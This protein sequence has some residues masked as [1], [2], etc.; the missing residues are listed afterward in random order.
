MTA[1]P[2]AD[3][4]VG[5]AQ[6]LKAVESASQLHESMCEL[7]GDP[8][9]RWTRTQVLFYLPDSFHTVADDYFVGERI[10]I[11]RRERIQ[12]ETFED[13]DLEEALR[14]FRTAAVPR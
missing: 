6:R 3:R 7:A 9:C 2:S 10:V 4:E 13:V 11:P 14:P 12:V 5:V 8:D 1:S